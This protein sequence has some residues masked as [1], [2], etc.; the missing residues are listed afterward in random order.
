MRSLDS[1]GA[2]GDVWKIG[3]HAV[4]AK[5]AELLELRFCATVIAGRQAPQAVL[6]ER[7]DEHGRAAIVPVMFLE[8]IDEVILEWE[9]RSIGSRW[10]V[11][12]PGRYP[13]DARVRARGAP[14]VQSRH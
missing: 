13:T 2:R 4:D 3:E 1:V 8:S 14:P 11:S 5:R 9:G 6:L 7:L 12:F 10:G